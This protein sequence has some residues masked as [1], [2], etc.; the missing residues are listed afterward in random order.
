MTTPT[1]PNEFAMPMMSH[2]VPK[3]IQPW[4]YMLFTVVIQMVNCMYPDNAALIMGDLS[5]MREDV[6]MIAQ[7]GIFSVALPFPFLFKLKFAYTNRSLLM[8]ALSG[9]IACLLLSTVVTWIPMLCAL[10]FACGFM[11]LMA[12]FECFSNIQ[13]WMTPRRDFQVFFPLIYCVIVGD[14]SLSGWI[15]VYL[16][17]YTGA[18][19]SM[20]LLVAFLLFLMLLFVVFFTHDFRIMKPIPFVSAD[21]LGCL[22]WA[23][24]ILELIFLFIYG[25]YYN[26]TDGAMWRTVA[27]AVP[28][29]A[30][31]A[32]QRMRHIRHPYIEEKAFRYR[33]LV[34]LLL[35]FA[36]ADLMNSTPKVLQSVF[37]SSITHYGIL[38]TANLYIPG[39]AGTISGCMFCLWWTKILRQKYTTLLTAGF[40]LLLGYQVMMYFMVGPVLNYEML[41]IPVFIRD[42]GYV[43][44]F[45]TLT[46]YM[47]ELMSFHHF[48]MGLTIAGFIRNGLMGN[49]CSGAYSFLLRQQIAD[50]F[51]RGIPVDYMQAVMRA[52]KTLYGVTCLGGTLMLLLMLAWHIEPVRKTFKKMPS[53]IAVGRL[54]RLRERQQ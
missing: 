35:M 29:T 7:F 20:H 17:Y 18:W 9:M 45:V 15:A 39:L 48:F 10:S 43:I 11:K 4:V 5:I 21:W 30:F 28:L 44:F 2:R 25:E 12:T 33:T 42:F 26:W 19:Q 41:L 22:L 8:F 32:I 46:I 16:A 38:A 14:K 47:Q 23:S 37:T 1:I 3:A 49:L 50:S 27:W 52:V 13:L 31:I 40:I 54:V 34:P 36:L 24:L 53:W 6:M 51:A